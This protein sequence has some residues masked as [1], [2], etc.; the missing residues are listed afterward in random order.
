M[1]FIYIVVFHSLTY[2]MYNLEP[3]SHSYTHSSTYKLIHI[4]THTH[5]HSSTYTLIHIHTHPHTHLYTYTLIHI[6]TYTHTYSSTYTII[7]IYTYTHTHSYTYTLIHI[8]TYTH[9]TQ[10]NNTRAVL[11]KY[12]LKKLEQLREETN[13]H[14]LRIMSVT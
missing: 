11:I 5:T 2:A 8:H 10:P 6:H 13:D 3:I 7:H 9:T 4:H 14:T 1:H 12:I